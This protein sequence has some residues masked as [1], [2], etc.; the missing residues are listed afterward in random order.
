MYDTIKITSKDITME[1]LEASSSVEL[2]KK[3]LSKD[4]ESES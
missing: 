3:D 2:N 1:K 4:D